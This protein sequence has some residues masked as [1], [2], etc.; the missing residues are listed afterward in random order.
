MSS[1]LFQWNPERWDVWAYLRDN[2]EDDFSEWTWSAVG[3]LDQIEP[4]DR[5]VFWIGGRPR[6]RGVYATGKVTNHA[7]G[8]GGLGEYATRSSDRH[9]SHWFVPFALTQTFFDNPI[10]AIELRMDPR[11]SQALIL[12]MPGGGNPFPLEEEEWKAIADRLPGTA[13]RTAR[14]GS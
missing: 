6:V 1:W 7:F 4:G 3:Y 12:R 8:G 14:Y 11:F 10:L 9:R 5:V 2:P 13:Y